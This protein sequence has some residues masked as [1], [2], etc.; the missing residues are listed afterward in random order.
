LQDAT[1]LG[2]TAI[3]SENF[4]LHYIVD[5]KTNKVLIVTRSNGYVV[6]KKEQAETMITDLTEILEEWLV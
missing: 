2:L 4:K 1:N 3:D 5:K 6:L